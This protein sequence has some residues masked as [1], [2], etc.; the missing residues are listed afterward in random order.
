MHSI[1][2]AVDTEFASNRARGLLFG[3]GGISWSNNVTPLLDGIVGDELHTNADITGHR[4]GQVGVESFANVLLV[5]LSNGLVRKFR[6]FELRNL[7]AGS[8]DLVKDLSEVLIG[9]RLDHSEGSGSSLFETVAGSH[10]AI[11][12]DFHD[13]GEDCYFSAH[14]EVLKLNAGNLDL[15]QE[16]A[17][18]FDVVHLDLVCDRE[19]VESVLADEACLFIVP[20]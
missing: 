15:L 1:E 17:R 8:V 7:E 20:V 11:V 19:K 12:G 18:V 10:I 3:N 16:D 4:S 13:T 6:H 5:K 9:M 2:S 14:V